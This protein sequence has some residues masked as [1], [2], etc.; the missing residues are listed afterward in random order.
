MARE[1]ED[2]G[3]INDIAYVKSRPSRDHSENKPALDYVLFGCYD[4]IPPSENFD[5]TY[6]IENYP[7]I[8][9]GET[10]PL[11]HFIKHGKNEKRIGRG[12]V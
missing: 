1:I 5:D 11:Y 4:G 12:T 2:S 10:I 7:D 9:N 6:Y 3:F 8:A